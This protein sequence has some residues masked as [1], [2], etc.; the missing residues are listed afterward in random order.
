MK[1][2]DQRENENMIIFEINEKT[3]KYQVQ[4]TTEPYSELFMKAEL[5][6]PMK[7]VK[8]GKLMLETKEFTA[9]R[10]LKRQDNMWFDLPWIEEMKSG[11]YRFILYTDKTCTGTPVKITEK[12][13]IGEKKTITVKCQGIENYSYIKVI[14]KSSIEIDSDKLYFRLK[15]EMTINKRERF[16]FP[17][18][19]RTEQGYET[20]VVLYDNEAYQQ[21]YIEAEDTIRDYL[22][23]K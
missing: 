3:K 9:K 1:K 6:G 14:L 19:I 5:V 18:M 17:N 4:W 21:M 8:N 22:V 2:H 10:I 20:F 15:D 16:Y 13:Y 7:T 23:I 12:K 11:T